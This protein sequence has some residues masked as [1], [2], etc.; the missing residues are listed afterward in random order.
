MQIFRRLIHIIVDEPFK[1]GAVGRALGFDDGSDARCRMFELRFHR[2][3]RDATVS[4]IVNDARTKN[5]QR[6]DDPVV[7]QRLQHADDRR[8]TVDPERSVPVGGNEIDVANG[9]SRC[10][11]EQRRS[12]SKIV[13]QED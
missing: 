3:P 1:G 7:E 5:L 6:R 12:P 2:R 9:C 10:V 13:P 11:V 8:S 4:L